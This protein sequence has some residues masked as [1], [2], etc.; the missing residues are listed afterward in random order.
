M[1][2]LI[3]TLF[4]W[5]LLPFVIVFGWLFYA[6]ATFLMVPLFA[7]GSAVF[8]VAMHGLVAMCV[9]LVASICGREFVQP[10][11]AWSIWITGALHAVLALTIVCKFLHECAYRDRDFPDPKRTAFEKWD[12]F[13]Y[14]LAWQI[15]YP[16][17]YLPRLMDEREVSVDY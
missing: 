11:M 3:G 13:F 16:L 4:G 8:A 14:N 6:A 9:G 5:L 12:R 17:G 10:A 7:M 2:K 15:F 1:C